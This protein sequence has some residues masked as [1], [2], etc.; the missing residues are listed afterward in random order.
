MEW[1]IHDSLLKGLSLSHTG[2]YCLLLSLVGAAF[3]FSA[4]KP[5]IYYTHQQ[6]QTP[7]AQSALAYVVLH[8]GKGL[9]G[10][11]GRFIKLNMDCIV[12]AKPC[13]TK[14]I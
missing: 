9:L 5:C 7:Q 14:S 13:L 1:I 3:L 12:L 6:T 10:F 2:I 8:L 11:P 4:V